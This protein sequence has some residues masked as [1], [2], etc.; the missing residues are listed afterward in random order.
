MATVESRI[1]KLENEIKALKG[2]YQTAGVLAKMYVVRSGKISV[3]G[4]ASVH[5][6]EIEFTPTKNTGQINLVELTATVFYAVSGTQVQM[7]KNYIQ[8][9]QSGTGQIIIKID[10]VTSSDSVEVIASGTVPGT[11]RLIS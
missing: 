1:A 11:F 2:T 5:Q 8:E 9:P 3:G 10:M 7:S 4:S 6:I